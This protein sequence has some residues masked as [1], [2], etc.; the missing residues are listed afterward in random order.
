MAAFLFHAHEVDLD[1]PVGRAALGGGVRGD[2]L[3]RAIPLGR[4]AAGL[5]A[6]ADQVVGD[7]RGAAL[8]ELQVAL[9]RARVVGVAG[10]AYDRL[11]VFLENLG[12]GVQHGEEVLGQGVGADGEGY[13]ARHVEH[14]VLGVDFGDADARA[15]QLGAELLVLVVHV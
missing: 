8:G 2:G 4:E 9:G 7:G 5:H 3:Q 6:L 10:D 15:L 11:V 1:A 13:V 14:D 12:D